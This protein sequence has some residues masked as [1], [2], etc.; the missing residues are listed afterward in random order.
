MSEFRGLMRE[1]AQTNAWKELRKKIEQVGN[2]DK[3]LTCDNIEFERGFI[4]GIRYVIKMVEA[5]SDIQSDPPKLE[6]GLN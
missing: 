2:T 1:F 6:Q 5:N 3:L 4:T